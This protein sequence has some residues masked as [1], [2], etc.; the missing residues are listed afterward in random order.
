MKRFVLSAVVVIAAAGCLGRPAESASGEDIYLQLC[1]NCHG[2]GMEG[3]LGPALGFG[4]NAMGQ[5]DEFLRVSI[6]QGRGRMPSFASSLSDQ[7]V[8]LLIGYIREG[9]GR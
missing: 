8:D 1:S 5:P 4:S 2:P 7:Q 9:Q 3:G 6:L